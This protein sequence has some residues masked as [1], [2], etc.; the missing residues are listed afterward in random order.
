MKLNFE[1]N[2]VFHALIGF[3]CAIYPSIVPIWVFYI[4]L[5]DGF[6]KPLTNKYTLTKP[7]YTAAYLCG[8]E[9]IGRMSNSGLPHELTKYAVI[10][11]LINGILVNRRSLNESVYP[12][13]VFILIQ[14]P[15]LVYAI[16]NEGFEMARQY[17]SFNLSGPLCLAVS[18]IYFYNLRL[19]NQDLI[20]LIQRFLYPI[21]ATISWLFISTPSVSEI[22]F[23]YG[24]NFAASGYGPNQMASLL[25]FGI[26]IIGFGFLFKLRISYFP[27]TQLIIFILCIY[28]GLLTFS[29]G[30]VVGPFIVLL[31]VYLLSV[32]GNSDKSF[33]LNKSLLNYFTAF[34]LLIFTL[35][36]VNDSTGGQLFNRYI[37]ISNDEK[38]DTEKYTSGRTT[39]AK[40]DLEIFSDNLLFGVG[41]GFATD[42]RFD[43]GYVSSVAAHIEFTRLLAEHGI[44]GLIALLI[45]LFFPIGRF[46]NSNNTHQRAL[47]IM[48]VLFCFLFMTHSATRIA[49]P[50]F[51][52][53]LGFA[54]WHFYLME[55]H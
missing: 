46:F 34:V 43:Y 24:A 21:I 32:L 44:F 41:P 16:G 6:Y 18:T 25:G 2:A 20:I 11:V 52:Y 4:I 10:V 53:G 9:M 35:N 12:I 45:M 19:T 40:I 26:L 23:N 15:S 1:Y 50:V 33:K 27:I 5:V 51:V 39:I 49:L 42:L 55:K 29:R 36:Y 47:L 37:G 54:R 13:I 48:G 7:H 3:I 30:G 28:R 17:F 14:L 8:L 31:T 38:V 22:D